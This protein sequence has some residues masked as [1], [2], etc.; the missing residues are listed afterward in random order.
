MSCLQSPTENT[1]RKERVYEELR[2]EDR[3]GQA[4]EII[5][6]G[7][8][9][10]AEGNKLLCPLWCPLSIQDCHSRQ[11][12]QRSRAGIPHGGAFHLQLPSHLTPYHTSKAGQ[13]IQF[14]Y[15]NDL[16]SEGQL[17]THRQVS[18]PRLAFLSLVINGPARK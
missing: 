14:L 6:C 3:R 9:I 2:G 12:P 16:H 4:L 8:Q 7:P 17:L 13:V 18:P 10:V 1:N 15:V 11:C 5:Y